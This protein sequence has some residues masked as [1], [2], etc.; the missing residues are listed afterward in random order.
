MRARSQAVA[1]LERGLDRM[2]AAEAAALAAENQAR[3]AA[4]ERALK[5]R[6]AAIIRRALGTEL[7]RELLGARVELEDSQ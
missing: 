4:R 3:A 2:R 1:E 7:S 6:Y 5:D